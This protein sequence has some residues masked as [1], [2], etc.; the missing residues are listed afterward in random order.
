[1]P[2]QRVQSVWEGTTV[3]TVG[4]PPH[5]IWCAKGLQSP[6]GGGIREGVKRSACMA[7]PAPAAMHSHPVVDAGA[8]ATPAP[9]SQPRLDALL[10]QTPACVL[11]PCRFFVSW[12][13]VLTLAYTGFPPA[14]ERL[15]RDLSDAIPTLPKENPGSK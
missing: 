15:K 1:M 9:A 2:Y 10:A 11:M 6:R 3:A 4:R 8:A 7:A 5:H 12:S 14:L 13:G